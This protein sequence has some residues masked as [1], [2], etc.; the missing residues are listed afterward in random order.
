MREIQQQSFEQKEHQNINLDEFLRSLKQSKIK[1]KQAKEN[2]KQDL[3]EEEKELQAYENYFDWELN[4]W[5]IDKY[6]KEW[7]SKNQET[8]E[9]EKLLTYSK[10]AD[11]SYI[12]LKTNNKENGD[13][14]FD[15][16]T[17][18]L[19]PA[20]FENINTLFDNPNLSTLTKE[21]LF[22][23][24]FINQNKD[25]KF[26]NKIVLNNETKEILKMAWFQ[27]QILIVND[28]KYIYGE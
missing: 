15:F 1:I 27:G 8:N 5:D 24:N 13:N 2:S 18:S 14:K 6:L 26:E 19:D 3:I 21:E 20:S 16:L 28:Y 22:L 9:K 10:L 17:V 25:K 4:I 7:K 12:H 23:Y 11:L